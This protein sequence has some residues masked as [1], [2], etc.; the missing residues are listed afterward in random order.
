MKL[1][2]ASL[3]FTGHLNFMVALARKMRSRGHEVVFI[4]I[5]DIEPTIRDA[6]LTFIPLAKRAISMGGSKTKICAFRV[7]PLRWL[8]RPW[9]QPMMRPL[10]GQLVNGDN[11][12]HDLFPGNLA[13]HG[14]PCWHV[15]FLVHVLA[16]SA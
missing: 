6:G 11:N 3:P 10:T 5:P 15:I 7:H 12:C 8:T 13:H 16:G 2:F 14:R 4:G 1:G 9:N